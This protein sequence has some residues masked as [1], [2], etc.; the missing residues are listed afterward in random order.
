MLIHP[1]NLNRITKFLSSRTCQVGSSMQVEMKIH[2]YQL[3]TV[4][5]LACITNYTYFAWTNVKWESVDDWTMKRSVK[6]IIKMN[7]VG[8][9]ICTNKMWENQNQMTLIKMIFHR[10]L[11]FECK[12]N[13]ID[14]INCL[15]KFNLLI[16]D[17]I[18]RPLHMF[19]LHSKWFYY[20]SVYVRAFIRKH[21]AS[22]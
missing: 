16:L 17:L 3:L 5:A 21:K 8:C 9:F 11:K 20:F 6:I 1:F 22:I 10:K 2:Q 19:F 7:D 4:V 18:Y 14:T 15:Y 12:F 13:D